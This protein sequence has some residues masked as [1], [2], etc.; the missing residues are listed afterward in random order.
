MGTTCAQRFSPMFLY[1]AKQTVSKLI[2]VESDMSIEFRGS[3]PKLF[4][5]ISH[6]PNPC[7][8]NLGYVSLNQ[9]LGQEKGKTSE[10]AKVCT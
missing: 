4:H 9:P 1:N 2:S 8:E 5:R 10:D 6:L 3:L 7:K